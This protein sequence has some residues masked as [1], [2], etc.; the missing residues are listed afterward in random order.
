MEELLI[1]KYEEF[2]SEVD[3]FNKQNGYIVK[4]NYATPTFQNF[5]FWLKHGYVEIQDYE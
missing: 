5:M 4:Y 2:L 1:K 3:Q